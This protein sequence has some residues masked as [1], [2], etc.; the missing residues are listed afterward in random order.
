MVRPG[1]CAGTCCHTSAKSP[2]TSPVMPS[3]IIAAAK[4]TRLGCNVVVTAL[5]R[6]CWFGATSRVGEGPT[7]SAIRM[8]NDPRRGGQHPRNGELAPLRRGD[9]AGECERQP[10]QESEQAHLQ[11]R[12]YRCGLRTDSGEKGHARGEI[13]T[14]GE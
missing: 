14:S 1:T 2:L 13:C 7:G 8:C 12:Q 6:D 10:H 11:R 4:N 9:G 5:P 3:A